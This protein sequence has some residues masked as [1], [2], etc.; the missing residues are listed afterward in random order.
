MVQNVQRMVA[1]GFLAFSV[2][3]CFGGRSDSIPDDASSEELARIVYSQSD[4]GDGI[5]VNSFLWSASLQ[6]LDFV[7]IEVTDS[8]GGVIETEW[9]N[10]PDIPTERFRIRV[11][12][13]DSRLRSD[14]I[15]LNLFKQVYSGDLGWVNTQADPESETRIENAILTRA[16]ELRNATIDG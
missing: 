8:S 11:T 3:A 9:Y 16:R 15:R 5:G 10:H 7:P 14:A 4:D 13:L 12:I 1:V 6:T 2:S